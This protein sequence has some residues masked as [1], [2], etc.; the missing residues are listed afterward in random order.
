M[1][2][3]FHYNLNQCCQQRQLY[4]TVPNNQSNI[5]RMWVEGASTG[6]IFLILTTK[7]LPLQHLLELMKSTA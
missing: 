3:P 5:C 6:S 2:Q 7:H 4:F 1:E